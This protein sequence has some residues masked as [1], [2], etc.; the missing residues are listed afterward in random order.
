MHES[1]NVCSFPFRTQ[2]SPHGTI[3]LCPGKIHA[4]IQNGHKWVRNTFLDVWILLLAT[5][6]CCFGCHHCCYFCCHSLFFLTP[7]FPR[8][9]PPCFCW[10]SFIALLP[11]AGNAINIIVGAYATIVV[12]NV[13]IVALLPSTLFLLP[14][15]LFV[16][17]L[18][19]HCHCPL[20]PPFFAD[21]LLQDI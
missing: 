4:H 10:S 20:L 12:G 13:I 6:P 3:Q 2:S 5:M 15:T 7:S 21:H 11:L 1:G 16:L 14:L 18:T 17:A 19:L 9:L 8:C